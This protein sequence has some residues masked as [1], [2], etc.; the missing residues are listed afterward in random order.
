M[1]SGCIDNN[2]S[3]FQSRNSMTPVL[4]PFECVHF[5]SGDDLTV[6]FVLLRFQSLVAANLIVS[7]NGT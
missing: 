6:S 2:T 4:Y 1:K 5:P 3:G 7:V